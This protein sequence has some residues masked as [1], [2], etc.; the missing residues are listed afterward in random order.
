MD[1]PTPEPANKPSLCPCL[2][3]VNKFIALT[4][5]SILGPNL[6]LPAAAGGEA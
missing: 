5:K 2:H 3:V 4:P 6:A 1:F